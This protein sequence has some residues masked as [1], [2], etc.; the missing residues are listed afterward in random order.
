[1]TKTT[2]ATVKVDS[3]IANPRN[4]RVHPPEDLGT[5]D[6]LIRRFGQSRSL[7]PQG[8][9]YADRR[10]LLYSAMKSFRRCHLLGRRSKDRRR[11]FA[12]RQSND[13]S[14]AFPR[15]HTRR[16]LLEEIPKTP[17]KQFQDS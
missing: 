2:R 16:A 10:S 11:I 15:R 3:I 8:Q 5:L 13:R 4:N 14:V 12:G 1:M 6:T 7:E 9:S 17:M